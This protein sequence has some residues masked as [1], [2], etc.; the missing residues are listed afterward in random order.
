MIQTLFG[1][2]EEKKTGFFDRMKQAVTRTRENLAESIEDVVSFGREIDRST[3][4]ELEGILIGA[5]LGT[6]PKGFAAAAS[7]AVAEGARAVCN[8]AESSRGTGVELGGLEDNAG[9]EEVEELVLGTAVF[10]AEL[11]GLS[12]HVFRGRREGLA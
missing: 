12:E 2:T 1:S 3:L 9:I 10:K 4:D 5:D 8:I 11:E 6:E 7:A